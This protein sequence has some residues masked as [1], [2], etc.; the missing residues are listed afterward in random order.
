MT[1]LYGIK[2]CDRVKKARRWLD[3]QSIDYVFQDV[4]DEPLK[5]SALKQWVNELGWEQIVNKRSTTWKGLSESVRTGMDADAAVATI[6]D[7][8][9]LMKRPLLD[10]GD[11]RYTG[12][13]AKQYE[14]IFNQ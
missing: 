6:L 5:P 13:S 7:Q 10:T 3:D 9:T 2:N 14:D 12:F 4:R 11:V 1:T 8:P